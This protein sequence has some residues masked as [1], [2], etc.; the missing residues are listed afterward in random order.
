MPLQGDPL[1]ETV[2]I[3]DAWPWDAGMTVVLDEVQQS[4]EPVLPLVG[5]GGPCPAGQLSESTLTVSLK[6][7]FRV[8]EALRN[9]PLAEPETIDDAG[10]RDAGM[11]VVIDVAQEHPEP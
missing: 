7:A 2:A 6:A 1:A 9:D 10:R 11:T 5:L 3:D 8:Q 4:R